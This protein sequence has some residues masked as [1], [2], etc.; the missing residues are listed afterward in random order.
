M[1]E[2]KNDGH[3]VEAE[4]FSVG[5]WNGE[6]FSR[7][8]LEE[9]ARNFKTMKD[10]LRPPLKFGHDENQ[11]LLNQSDGDPSLGW[12]EALRVQGEKLLAT[13]CGVPSVVYEAIRKG[14]Y[15][16]VSA[17]L[18][19]N[20]RRDGKK[21]G[22]VLKAVALLGADLPAVTNLRELGAYL[23]TEQ[24]V[25]LD[26][27]SVR[28]FSW[29]AHQQTITTH[30]PEE[31]SMPDQEIPEEVQAEMAELRA[32]REHSEEEKGRAVQQRKFEAFRSIRDHAVSF[33]D[34]QVREGRLSPNQRHLLVRE[35]ESNTREF[36]EGAPLRISFSWVKKF[37][38]E[39]A[40]TLPEGEIGF[41]Q[42]GVLPEGHA[43]GNSSQTLA[44]LAANK[45]NEL[46]LSYTEASEYVLRTEPELARAYREFT[47]N[48]NQ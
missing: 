9:I 12:V 41:S 19:F 47:L 33:C 45:M 30:Q 40:K 36:S 29:P 27:A 10:R 15:Q 34:E 6:R 28:T 1:P 20:V 16:R 43:D 26:A 2:P 21:L 35:I 11:T 25:S 39:S 13:F 4:I 37:I 7:R 31:L 8:D 23:A 22:K 5:E 3:S 18:Y 38:S 42:S 46:N 32:Y 44:R 14:R 24:P 48:P 17:E